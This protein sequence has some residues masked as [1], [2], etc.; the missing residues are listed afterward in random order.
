VER[1]LYYKWRIGANP[2]LRVRYLRN[3][4]VGK[5][6]RS[7]RVTLDRDLLFN[8]TYSPIVRLADDGWQPWRQ[9]GVVLEI[10]FTGHCPRWLVEVIQRFGL[11]SRSL[12]KYA[13]GVRR[14]SELRSCAP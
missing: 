3:A 13:S 8:L 9:H 7:V 10:K 12:S 5:T 11:Q 1:F 6:D 14:L 4:L 2:I